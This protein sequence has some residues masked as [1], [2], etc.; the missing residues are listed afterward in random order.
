M[1][2]PAPLV[3]GSTW[4]FDTDKLQL[5][6]TLPQIYIDVSARGYINP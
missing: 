3:P 2:G 6:V 1:S 4:T 5:N